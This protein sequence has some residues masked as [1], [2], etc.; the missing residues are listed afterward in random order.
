MQHRKQDELLRRP[1]RAQNGLEC[2]QEQILLGSY[3]VTMTR[4]AM[5][6]KSVPEL[7]GLFGR[8]KTEHSAFASMGVLSYGLLG[9]RILIWTHHLSL[10]GGFVFQDGETHSD[11]G[12]VSLDRFFKWDEYPITSASFLGD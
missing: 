8:Q 9:L 5:F 11:D 6:V 1:G 3:V 7:S 10:A 4:R 12:P 2:H